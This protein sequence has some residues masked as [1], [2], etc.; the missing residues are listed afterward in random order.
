[1]VAAILKA[2]ELGTSRPELRT[3]L[4]ENAAYF[5]QQLTGLG[6][7]TGNSTTYIMPL[8]IGD[9]ERMY[10]IGHELRQRG[11]WVAPVDYPAVPQD[12]ICFRACVTANHTRADLDEA[13]NIL[14]DT[15]VPAQ[16]QH[17]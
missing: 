17:A 11:L 7:D 12:R 3:R 4:W 2:L 14:S 1:V 15:L 5:H 13:L 10:R 16:M 6:I 9:R 8:V